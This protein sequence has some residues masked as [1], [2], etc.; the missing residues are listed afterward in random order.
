MGTRLNRN[1]DWSAEYAA[2]KV[3]GGFNGIFDGA[4]KDGK[5]YGETPVKAR[6]YIILSNGDDETILLS[7]QEEAS[8]KSAMNLIMNILVG[9]VTV[10]IE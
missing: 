1:E 8:L 9:M 5:V 4:D 2:V 7:G 3:P 6:A 10:V